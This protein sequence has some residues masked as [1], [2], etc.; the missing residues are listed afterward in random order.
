LTDRTFAALKARQ[1]DLQAEKTLSQDLSLRVHRA[2]SWL[3]RAEQETARDDPDAS[4]IFHWIAFNAAYADDLP[5]YDSPSEKKAFEKYFERLMI[6]D[7]HREIYGAIVENFPG[8]ISTLLKNR[9]VFGPFW[10]AQS[11]R[12]QSEDWSRQFDRLKTTTEADLD[13]QHTTR[14]LVEIFL[15]LNVLRNQLIH[16]GATWRG[17]VNREQVRDGALILGFLV[18][19]FVELMMESPTAEWG[20]PR[21]PHTPAAPA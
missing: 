1:H 19:L 21:Y 8:E 12:T 16:G 14:V 5:E 13:K 11:K 7:K 10:S 2:L 18:P 17:R 4:F 20:L 15:R 3:G 9:Y 6:A